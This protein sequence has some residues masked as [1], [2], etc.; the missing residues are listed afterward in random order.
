MI[1]LSIS[2]ILLI[3]LSF[4]ISPILN[5][6]SITLSSS[7]TDTTESSYTISS[8]IVT[9]TDDEEYTITGSCS[10]CG[11]EVKKGASPTITLSSIKIDNSLTGPFVI[12]SGAN[13]N[14]ILEGSSTITDQQADEDEQAGIKFKSSSS[15]TISGDGTLI[16]Y[17]YSKNGI[18]GASGS[19]LVIN[20]GT[21]NVTCV[22]NGIAADG[23][24]TINGGIFNIKTSEGDG[25]KSDPDYNDTASVGSVT[26]TGGTF[27]INSYN[28]GIQAK[29]KLTISGGTFN[30]KTFGGGSSSTTF[31]KDLY[32]AKGIKVST[33]ETTNISMVISGGTFKLDTAD[34]SVH[35]DGNITITG[36]TFVISSGDD[37]IHADQ[38]LILGKSG[39]SNSNLKINITKSYEGLEGAQIYIYSGTYRVIASDDGINSAGDTTEDCDNFGGNAGPGGNNGQRGNNGPRNLVKKNLRSRKRTL[40]ECSSFH[41][42]VYGGNIY[43]NAEADGLDANG[44]INIYGG[45]LEVWGASRNADG[46]FADLDGT[47]TISGGTFFGG[48][49]AGMI[50]PSRWTNSQQAIYGRNQISANNVVYIVSGSTTITSY[51]SPKNIAYLY[52]TSPSATSSYQFSTTAPSNSGSTTDSTNNANDSTDNA[53]DEN[54]DV[55]TNSNTDA[56]T[57]DTDD[58]IE[59]LPVDG[60]W[61]LK[62]NLLYLILTILAL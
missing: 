10:E 19:T 54:T 29:D 26:I 32:S 43:V 55:N 62:I 7:M 30:I 27:N 45:N 16:V 48:G 40:Q 35:S 37:G 6:V 13:V 28:D 15:L 20:S 33:N 42:Y 53:D 38:N 59:I 52:Y 3:I 36:G 41:L 24:V 47:M 31:D 39:D 17:G 49:N 18:K 61:Y 50:D 25:I 11:I 12:K 60:H 51:T 34:D 22:N 8:N 5:S 57:E 44:N 23:S 46:D 14:L 9:L 56:N 4:Q 1:K 2:I 58:S 21:F